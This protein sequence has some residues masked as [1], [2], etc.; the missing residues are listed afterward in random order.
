M[1][2]LAGVLFV[3]GVVH[4]SSAG[5]AMKYGLLSPQART[6]LFASGFLSVGLA[7]TAVV[8]VLA[9]YRTPLPLGQYKLTAEAT[10]L[11]YWGFVCAGI[12]F[13]VFLI[14]QTLFHVPVA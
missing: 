9:L 10:P 7:V 6:W 12:V 11:S 14:L 2:K 13:G 4:M 1:K 8:G 5:I 3:I